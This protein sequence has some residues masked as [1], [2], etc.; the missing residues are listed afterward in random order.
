MR[1][2]ALVAGASGLIGRRI[3]EHLAA[4]GWEVIRLGRRPPQEPGW[5][6]V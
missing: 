3:A 1:H 2:T 5:I 6:G 4:T